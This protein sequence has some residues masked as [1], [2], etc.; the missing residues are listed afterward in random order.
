[1][2]RL[3]LTTRQRRR[4]RHQLDTTHDVRVY[5]RTLAILEVDQ[6]RSIPEIAH[7]LG[8]APRS[9][10]HWIQAYSHSHD[11]AALVDG[12]RPGRPR[13]GTEELGIRLQAILQTPPQ[14]LGYPSVEWTVPLLQEHLEHR[15]GQWFSDE[16]F[17]RRLQGLGYV[18]K[19]SRYVL[20]PDPELEKKTADP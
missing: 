6:G 19:R 7:A 5:R 4:L 1:M 2:D 14:D 17:R 8:V 13:R 9:V 16:T 10:Y 12:D 3:T 18:W 20:Q 11:P 15:T